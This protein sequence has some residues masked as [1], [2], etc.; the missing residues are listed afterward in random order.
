M[1]LEAFLWILVINFAVVILYHIICLVRMLLKKKEKNRGMWVKTLVMLLAPVVGPIFFFVTA[2]LDKTVFR[3]MVDLED[4]IFSKERVK[5]YSYADDAERNYVP[6]EEAMVVSETE[7]LRALTLNLVRGEIHNS[8]SAIF[9]VLNSED[10]ETSH[11]AAS[12]LQEV[13]D[14]FRANVQKG[15]QTVRE[16]PK[17]QTEY[18]RLMIDYMNPIL[19]QK[20]FTDLEQ[21][22][23]V[24]LMDEM[25]EIVFENE[26]LTITSEQFEAI[27]MRL[28]EIKDY[29]NCQKWCDRADY[30][31]PEELATYTCK[32]KLYFNTGKKYH[33]FRV[34]QDLKKSNII[35]DNETLE[36][37]RVFL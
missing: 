29:A 31:Y 3:T 11:Y 7:D 20:V 33:F 12:V 36:L 34:L 5:T 28:L 2:L 8:L 25:G 1:K 27:S 23:M 14:Q 35:V 30:F 17:H 19:I 15:I 16:D 37:I 13:L 10:S 21:N 32:L 26:R 22:A 6:I 4:V 9:A 24:H 18:A